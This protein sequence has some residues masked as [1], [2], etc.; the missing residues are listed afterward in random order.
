M[1]CNPIGFTFSMMWNWLF[2]GLIVEMSTTAFMSQYGNA[3]WMIYLVFFVVFLGGLV[4]LCVWQ[5][6]Q[7]YA[8]EWTLFD[9]V[10]GTTIPLAREV[11]PRL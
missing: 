4:K 2:V 5:S 10:A 9:S 7:Y 6:T 8:T 1:V 3:S 11:H